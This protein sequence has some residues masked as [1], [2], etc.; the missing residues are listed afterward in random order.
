MPRTHACKPQTGAATLAM[1]AVLLLVASLVALYAQRRLWFEQQASSNQVR[2]L[3]AS[4]LAQ[5]GL[6]WALAQLNTPSQLA[7]APSC[8]AGNDTP[9]AQLFRERY[10]TPRATQANLPKGLYPPAGASAGCTLTED[11]DLQCTCPLPGQ[12][13]DL[14]N[15][16]AGSF[17]VQFVTADGDPLAI[18]V[19]STGLA[20]Q[21][22]VVATTAAGGIHAQVRAWG[23]CL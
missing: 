1:A 16:Q 3:R 7:D 21:A 8:Q 20:D 12:A 13:L 9:G 15:T 22:E 6:E 10:A 18:D 19:L 17:V 23:R 11:G 14:P 4:E 5:A 2:S